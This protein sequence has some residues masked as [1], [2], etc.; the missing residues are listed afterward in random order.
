[1]DLELARLRRRKGLLGGDLVPLHQDAFRLA[2][3]L[4]GGQGL[5]ELIDLQGVRESY[6]GVCGG[7]LGWQAAP[8]DR[9]LVKDGPAPA[10]VLSTSYCRAMATRIRSSGVMRWS[11]L[12]SPRSIC[13]H[14]MSR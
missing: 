9:I 4:P 14:S 2:D 5:A 6:G 13:T 8:A 7:A 10:A 1:M 12:S 3:Q 11:W